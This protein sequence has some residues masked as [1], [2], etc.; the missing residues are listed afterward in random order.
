M[1][2]LDLGNPRSL[3]RLKREF[4]SLPNQNFF[5]QTYPVEDYTRVYYSIFHSHRPLPTEIETKPY[6]EYIKANP[7]ALSTDFLNLSKTAMLVIP[8]KPYVTIYDFAK[9]ATDREWLALFR[10]TRK[11]T[12]K[13]D[14]ISTHGLGVSWLH[15]RIENPPEYNYYGKLKKIK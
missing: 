4:A 5:L 14:T 8:I 15:V 9:R 10:R 6:S 3:L 2:Y 11:L 13:G 12:L 7:R 1:P